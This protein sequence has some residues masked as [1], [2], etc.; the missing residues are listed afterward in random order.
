[1]RNEDALTGKV[2]GH[3]DK[4]ICV[5]R[6]VLAAAASSR[7]VLEEKAWGILG[8]GG[9]GLGAELLDLSQRLL[10]REREEL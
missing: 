1:M 3:H 4:V 5:T 10:Q 2:D 9:K 6:G 7:R 8:R